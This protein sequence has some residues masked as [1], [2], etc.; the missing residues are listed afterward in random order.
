[1]A[2]VAALEVNIA[3]HAKAVRNLF[4]AIRFMAGPSDPFATP[5]RLIL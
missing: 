1:V 2:K 4:G 3:T 5:L